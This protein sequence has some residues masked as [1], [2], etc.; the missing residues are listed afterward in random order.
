MLQKGRSMKL[1]YL[2]IL[3]IAMYTAALILVLAGHGA[4]GNIL[5]ALVAWVGIVATWYVCGT[6]TYRYQHKR[7]LLFRLGLLVSLLLG[8]MGIMHVIGASVSLQYVEYV[9]WAFIA[10]VLLPFAVLILFLSFTKKEYRQH[11]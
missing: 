4:L 3:F 1:R 7:L 10:A 5:A 9:V 8:L 11:S 2:F 6:L